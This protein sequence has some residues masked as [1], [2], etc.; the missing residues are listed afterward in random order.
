MIVTRKRKN[1]LPQIT[2]EMN[3]HLQNSVFMKNHSTGVACCKHLW[4]GSYS[5][6]VRLGTESYEKTAGCQDHL[7]WAQLQW[8][9]VIWFDESSF[10]LFQ[11][12]ERVHY[13]SI[14]AD[15]LHPML[16]NLSLGERP[17]FHEH[18]VPVH[19]SRCVQTCLHGHD[20][21]VVHLTRCSQ[22]PELSIVECLWGFLENKIRARFLPLLILSDLEIALQEE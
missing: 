11:T 7:N 13:R 19:T 21:Y 10:T 9:Q 4:Q 5:K 20:D 14:L 6:A 12:T 3:T 15:H 17:M 8:E 22:S 18:N 2:F 1:I 16:Q